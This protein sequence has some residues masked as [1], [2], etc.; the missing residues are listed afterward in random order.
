MFP[1]GVPQDCIPRPVLKRNSLPN[2]VDP[3]LG[4]GG[5]FERQEPFSVARE[6]GM[7]V[8]YITGPSSLF[9]MLQYQN[10]RLQNR[11]VT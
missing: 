2:D 5:M 4:S 6:S 3:S 8:G 10:Q 9:T 7:F 1:L 11:K